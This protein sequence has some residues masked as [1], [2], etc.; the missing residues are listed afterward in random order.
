MSDGGVRHLAEIERLVAD[1]LGPDGDAVFVELVYAAVLGRPADP[2]GLEAATAALASGALSRHQ[3]VN[4]LLASDELAEAALVHDLT[5]AAR[6]EGRPFDPDRPGVGPATSERVVEV[7]WA[8]S[9]Y[10]GERRVLDVGYANAPPAYL[11]LLVGL[12]VPELHG[13]DL[14]T[15]GV[16]TMLRSTADVR[17]LPYPDQQFDLVLCI[18]TLEHVGHDNTRYGLTVERCGGDVDAMREMAR[19]LAPGGR[20]LA[21]VPA[22]REEH[23][24][25]FTQYSME[26]WR[27]LLAATPLETEE[28]ALYRLEPDGWARQHDVAAVAGDRYGDGSPGARAV[29]CAALVRERGF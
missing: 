21:T 17:R 13:A 14:A 5:A 20:L 27:A 4:D 9:R 10:R 24:E 2:T 26:G 15:R 19:V 28:E 29:L 12:E 16:P 7:P 8:L 18:S 25:W 6:R 23:F 1:T 11:R 3:L 22:G